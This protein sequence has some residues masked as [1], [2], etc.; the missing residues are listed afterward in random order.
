ML[1]TTQIRRSPTWSPSG[2]R[3]VSGRSPDA[4]HHANQVVS[5]VVSE[6]SLVVSKW[7]LN[8]PRMLCAT[9]IRWCPLSSPGGLRAASGCFSPQKSSGLRV[10]SGWSLSGLLMV[11]GWSPD[12]LCHTNQVVS[13]VVSGWSPSGLRAVSGCFS[14][15]KS[16][17]LRA[18]SAPEVV[19]KWGRRKQQKVRTRT[20]ERLVG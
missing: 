9:Q 19:K 4:F 17:G 8:G 2:L 11:S 12:A 14:P 13:G 1:S 7:S 3:V 10:V 18:A 15:H 6:W 5:G 16:A 20:C